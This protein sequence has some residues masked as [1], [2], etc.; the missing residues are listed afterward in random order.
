MLFGIDGLPVRSA[1]APENASVI[2][3]PD[4]VVGKAVHA[5]EDPVDFKY[6]PLDPLA[7]LT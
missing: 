4:S 2:P 1:Y 7:P 3:Y 6:S 5:T